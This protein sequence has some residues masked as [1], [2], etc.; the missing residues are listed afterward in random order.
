[1]GVSVHFEGR[2]RGEEAFLRLISR[3]E[4]IARE[5]TLLTETFEHQQV[6]LSRVRDEAAWDYIGPTKGIILYLHE[7]C[8]PVRL[9]FDRDLYIQEWVKTQFAGAL[10][11]IKLIRVLRD[12]QIFFEELKVDDEGEYWDTADEVLLAEHIRHCDQAIAEL[13]KESPAAEVKVR[14][15]NGRYTDLIR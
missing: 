4:Q 6:E 1:M 8:E 14:E 10:I 2:L 15:P 7:D 9:E 13:A 5:E 3:I 11:H 12:L